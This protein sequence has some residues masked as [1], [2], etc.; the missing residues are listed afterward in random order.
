MKDENIVVTSIKVREDKLRLFKAI[1]TI[2][3]MD[4]RTPIQ[5]AWDEAVTLFIEKNKN[6]LILDEQ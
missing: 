4:S 5:N 3:Y 2:K 6:I 1:A